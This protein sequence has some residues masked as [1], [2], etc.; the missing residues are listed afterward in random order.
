MQ[1]PLESVFDITVLKLGWKL[2]KNGWPDRMVVA[3]G[4]K[5]TFVEVKGEDEPLRPNQYN[6]GAELK[7]AGFDVKIAVNGDAEN[8]VDIDDWLVA[9]AN[10]GRPPQTGQISRATARSYMYKANRLLTQAE[11][12]KINPNADPVEIETLRTRAK[13]MIGKAQRYWDGDVT[14]PD[15]MAEVHSMDEHADKLQRSQHLLDQM[16]KAQLDEENRKEDL[17]RYGTPGE[18]EKQ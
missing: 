16:L 18:G 5:I 9:S 10:R 12:I 11:L 2:Y 7:R 6:F 17:K 8:L 13:S 3:T 14:A 1:S 4:G 15:L